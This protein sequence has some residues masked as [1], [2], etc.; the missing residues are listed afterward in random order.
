MVG[1][2]PDREVKVGKGGGTG[3]GWGVE[4]TEER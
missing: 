3:T 2:E 4:G 1:H